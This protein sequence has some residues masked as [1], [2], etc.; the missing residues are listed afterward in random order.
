MAYRKFN[1]ECSTQSSGMFD[2]CLVLASGD[3]GRG[4]KGP[5]TE[6][7]VAQAPDGVWW[8]SENLQILTPANTH[9]QRI[10]GT[11]SYTTVKEGGGR[12]RWAPS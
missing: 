8:D 5:S 3:W 7:S 11:I 10:L 4:D 6:G 9:F 12:C 2:L 1:L